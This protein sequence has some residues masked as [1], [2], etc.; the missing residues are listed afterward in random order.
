MIQIVVLTNERPGSVGEAADWVL[1][2]VP[3]VEH[4]PGPL[5]R[6]RTEINELQAFLT[7]KRR[8]GRQ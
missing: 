7:G 8:H 2:A 3:R 6:E 1:D 5:E 4:R